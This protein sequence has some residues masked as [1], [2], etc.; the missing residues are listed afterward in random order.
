MTAFLFPGQGSQQPGML[1]TPGLCQES[2]DEADRF[3]ALR[4]DLPSLADLDSAEGLCRTVNVQLA[5]FITG[6]AAAHALTRRWGL[7]APDVVAGHSIGAFA[8]AVVAGA[9][10]FTEALGAV[11]LRATMMEHVCAED[12]WGMA[13]VVGVDARTAAEL[14][15]RVGSPRDPLWVANINSR[16]QVV[17][18][19]TLHAL[20]ALVRAAERAGAAR[21]EQLDM[22]VASH[23]LLQQPTSQALSD[24]LTGILERRLQTPYLTNTRGQRVRTSGAV[25]ADLAEGVARTVQWVTIAEILPELGIVRAV[26]MP[27]GRVLS[28][29]TES[30][31]LQVLAAGDIGL[32]VAAHRLSRAP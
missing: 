18:G 20:R 6:T 1:S 3:L 21:V 10:T 32:D 9:L 27:P 30:P 5:L 12:Q 29:L 31:R 7:P 2:L 14:A 15:H 16:R 26:E 11:A 19:G 24:H 4:S 8:A 28:K 25:L 22:A 17:F 13:A 23:G